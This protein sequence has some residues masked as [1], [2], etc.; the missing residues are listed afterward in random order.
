MKRFALP[1]HSRYYL[2]Q[3]S[4]RVL[5]CFYPV[6]AYALAKLVDYLLAGAY[7]DVGCDEYLLKF[8]KEILVYLY[9]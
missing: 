2:A 8:I 6:V 5:A 1:Y 3:G 7:A 4:H 9:E